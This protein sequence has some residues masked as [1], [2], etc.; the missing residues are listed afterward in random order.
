M[1]KIIREFNMNLEDMAASGGS[2]SFTITGDTGAIFS[3]EI[4]N[5]DDYYYNFKTNTFSAT[6]A[7]LKQQ[8]IGGNGEYTGSVTF[9]SI[10]DNDHYDIYL[11]AESAYDTEH[12][13]VSEVR[14]GD[15][16]LDINST[17]GSNSN[18]VQKIIYQYTDTTITIYPWQHVN[19]GAFV[20]WIDSYV[21]DTIVVGRG[22][23]IKKSFSCTVTTG[24]TEAIQIL[25]QPEE[26]DFFSELRVDWQ[27]AALS[28]GG[29]STG[30]GPV[31]IQG[32]NPWA[33]ATSHEEADGTGGHTRLATV[34]G[35][36]YNDANKITVA[37]NVVTSK[38]QVGDRVTGYLTVAAEE[39]VSMAG[40]TSAPSTEITLVTAV[41]PDG[42]NVNEVSLDRNININD[43]AAIYF[44]APYYY[45]YKTDSSW[46]ATSGILGLTPRMSEVA[47]M[48][49]ANPT[50]TASD[51]GNRPNEISD[52]EDA[53]TYTRELV[54][55]DGSLTEETI[56]DI[57][58]SY[59][60]IET[61]GIKPT[62]TNGKI[63][64]QD[65]IITFKNPQK[66][67]TAIQGLEGS[68]YFYAKGLNW[69]KEIL[70]TEIRVTNLKVELTKPTTTTTSGVSN[71]TTVPVADREGTIQ[72][73][74]T[75]SGIGI[76]A[77]AANP[78]VTSATADGAGSWT[79]SAAQT[80][81]SG[82][83]LTVE[84]TGR[85]ATITGDIEIIKC[86][87]SNFNLIMHVPGFIT[88]A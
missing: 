63:T 50:M 51:G 47:N 82:I 61:A 22:K 3:L 2:R 74:S 56:K 84:G 6:K 17:L 16:S 52:Y 1:A 13:P 39:Q 62:I 11:W 64:A 46:G 14:F 20:S 69:T 79:L 35:S 48:V 23:S 9:P 28:S 60:P 31:P 76:A 30:G 77:G 85:T 80:L 54:A 29:A 19:G 15:G 10:T 25:R 27:R 38:V 71:S 75:V 55:S 81:E 33:E 66:I 4:K 42:D 73:V 67:D 78:T 68:T 87:S 49:D 34:A 57:N 24:A 72:N 40:G 8:V 5:E 53:T 21:A 41:N 26:S 45:R 65:G 32:E 83:T 86:G 18:L 12:A 58:I 36:T 88:G 59:P 43:S 70:D 37:A 44:N 7:K